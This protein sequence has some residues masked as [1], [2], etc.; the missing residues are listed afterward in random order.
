M[1]RVEEIK[2][3]LRQISTD[4]RNVIARWLRER[5][6]AESQAS[7]VEEPASNYAEAIPLYMT[8]EEYFEFEEKSQL[9]H[10]YV[11]GMVYAMSGASLAHNEIAFALGVAVRAH[12]RGGPCKAFINDVKLRITSATDNIV[13]YPDL[14]VACNPNEWGTHFVRNPKLVMEVLS[15]TTRDID[16]RE[17]ATAYRHISSIEEY[18]LIEQLEQKIV[19]QRRAEDWKPQVYA[20]PEAVAEFRSISLAAPLAQIYEGTLS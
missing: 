11:N 2:H 14:M 19:V 1:T 15:P 7:R 5:I 8:L 9:R 6:H 17:K 12:L 13:Y 20:G 4:E 18:V 16:R 10:E 3:T